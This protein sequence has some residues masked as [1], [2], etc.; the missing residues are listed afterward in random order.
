MNGR[1]QLLM[2]LDISADNLFGEVI[3]FREYQLALQRQKT[4]GYLA[5]RN[6]KVL[7]IEYLIGLESAGYSNMMQRRQD[8]QF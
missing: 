3:A 4:K 2:F 5:E 7:K 6:L 1:F 8:Q